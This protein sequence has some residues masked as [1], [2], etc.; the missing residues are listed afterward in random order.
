MYIIEDDTDVTQFAHPGPPGLLP[1]DYSAVP[2]GTM[3]YCTP[4]A[5]TVPIIPEN[6]WLP[7]IRMMEGK[8]IRSIYTG[9]P[10]ED[11]QNGLNYCWSFSLGQAI[12]GSRDADGQPHV[13]LCPES[14]GRDVN[15]RNAGNYCGSAIAAAAKWGMCDRSFSPKRYSLSPSTWTKGWEQEALSHRVLEWYELGTVNMWQEVVTALLLGHGVYFGVNWLSHAMWFSELQIVGEKI[16]AWTPNTWGDGEDMLLTG[17]KAIPDE[18]YV[19]RSSV[20][21]P[22]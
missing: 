7:R 16:G 20:W 3:P 2:I 19:I 8:F 13:D 21:S 18:A 22:K 15:W 6:E 12:K 14:L 4:F 9:T 1:R 5:A 10:P 17:A 11:T